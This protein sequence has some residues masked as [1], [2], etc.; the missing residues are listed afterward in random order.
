[1]GL[2]SGS[3]SSDTTN[4]TFNRSKKRVDS[5]SGQVTADTSIIGKGNK[6]SYIDAGALDTAKSMASS[7]AAFHNQTMS[8]VL[9]FLSDR[10]A[11]SSGGINYNK[12]ITGVIILGGIYLVLKVF[13]K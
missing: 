11:T 10:E 6:I 12:V 9:G 4:T 7:N 2:L 5:Y 8:D 1:M 13:K 3:S